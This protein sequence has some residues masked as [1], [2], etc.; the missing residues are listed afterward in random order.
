MRSLLSLVAFGR[1]TADRYAARSVAADAGHLL[2][3]L[4]IGVALCTIFEKLLP[5]L[6]VWGPPSWFVQDVADMGFAFPLLFAWAAVLSEFVGGVLLIVGLATRPAAF[7]IAVTTGVA[8]F[9]EHRG[10]IAGEGL[11]AFTFFVL[12]VV[13]ILIGPGRW[14]AD[15]VLQRLRVNKTRSSASSEVAASADLTASVRATTIER[16]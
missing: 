1:H 10:D 4:F 16:S 3:R 6:G 8:A 7:L 15:G 14:S 11:L 12:S 13:L 9:V 2:L 5:R